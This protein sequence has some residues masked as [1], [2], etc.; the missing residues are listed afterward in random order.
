MNERDGPSYP[1]ARCT[2]YANSKVLPALKIYY[3]N[4][5]VNTTAEQQIL[6]TRKQICILGVLRESGVL[7]FVFSVSCVDAIQKKQ[8]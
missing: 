3:E 7:S 6:Q 4:L 5:D 8:L 2:V 1:N